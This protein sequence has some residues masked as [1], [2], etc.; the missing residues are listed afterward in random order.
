MDYDWQGAWQTG[1]Y[2]GL[3]VNAFAANTDTGYTFH[4]LPWRPRIGAHADIASGGANKADGTMIAPIQ[5]MY[6]N[7]QYYVPNNEFAPTNFYDFAPRISVRPT[8]SIT[9]EYCAIS[10][11]WRY[12]RSDARSASARRAVAGGN[13]QNNYA[14]TVPGAGSHDRP[15][16]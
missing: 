12:S 1:S 13:G 15:A 6:P 2:A 4:D 10:F 9:A 16:I 14:V 7:T 11:L 5:P 8:E 3:T